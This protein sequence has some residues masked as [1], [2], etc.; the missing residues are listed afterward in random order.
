MFGIKLLDHCCL[1]RFRLSVLIEFLVMGNRWDLDSSPCL[2]A[3][4]FLV[5]EALLN[6]GLDHSR[7]GV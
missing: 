7:A 5:K 6:G 4:R 3:L 2:R 1:W